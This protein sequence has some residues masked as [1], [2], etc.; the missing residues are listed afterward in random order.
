MLEQRFADTFAL[1]FGQHAD[2]AESEHFVLYS[3]L[4]DNLSL[5]VHDV[6]DDLAVDLGYEIEFRYERR[7]LP[8]SMDQEMLVTAGLVY[9]PERL[10]GQ[11]LDEAIVCRFL[12]TKPDIQLY[13]PYLL[14]EVSL[15]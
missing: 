1:I 6:A 4:V 8:Q 9:A 5:G 2:G 12:Q 14:I 3:P 15:I 10:P 13:S 11:F 7:D